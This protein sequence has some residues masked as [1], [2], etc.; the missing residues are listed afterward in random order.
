M[1][2]PIAVRLDA[3]CYTPFTLQFAGNI[4]RDDYYLATDAAE[5]HCHITGRV[6]DSDNHHSF[7]SVTVSV[8]ACIQIH[9]CSQPGRKIA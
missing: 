7:A 9:R 6:T 4:I 8:S 2:V 1:L 3:N 5:V